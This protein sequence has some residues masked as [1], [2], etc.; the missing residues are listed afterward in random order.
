MIRTLLC[1]SVLIGA[2]LAIDPDSLYSDQ[3]NIVEM[4]AKKLDPWA[5]TLERKH[6]SVIQAS[7][8]NIVFLRRT[9]L[10]LQL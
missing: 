8:L 3:K 4:D 6:A 7:I 2:A 5:N 9:I 10:V 1:C